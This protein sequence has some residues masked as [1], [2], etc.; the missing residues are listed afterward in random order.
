MLRT[1]IEKRPSIRFLPLFLTG[2]LVA[3]TAAVY[4]FSKYG[5]TWA[6]LPAL[7]TAPAVLLVHATLVVLGPNRW[8]ELA[9]AG[10]HL[11]I[12]ALVWIG[13]LM[14]IAKDSF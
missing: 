13:A 14:L 1:L 7:I 4:P 5:D 2:F 11:A 10:L 6:I 12:F 3:W 9:Y 8:R